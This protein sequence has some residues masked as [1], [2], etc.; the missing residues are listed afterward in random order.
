MKRIQI[1]E[2]PDPADAR[3][4]GN[5]IAW[6]RD[7]HKWANETKGRIEQS[8]RQNDIP[9]STP[10]MVSSFTTRTELSGTDTGTAV[11]DFICTLVQ[12][13]TDRGMVTITTA[14]S[15]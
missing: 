4:K 2:A 8:S 15:Q 1:K 10:F 14:S 12:A 6:A 9:L 5:P 13:L 3:Y 11:S 7:M